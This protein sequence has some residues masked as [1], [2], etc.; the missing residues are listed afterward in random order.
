MNAAIPALAQLT[1]RQMQIVKLVAEDLTSKEIARRL[2]ISSK[3]VEFHKQRL[4]VRL[5]NPGTAKLV[6]L[7]IRFGWIEP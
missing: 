2:G 1:E 6:R 7:A 5:G 3:T 4:K